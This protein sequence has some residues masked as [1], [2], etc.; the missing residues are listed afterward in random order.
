M[1][2]KSENRSSHVRLVACVLLCC[3]AAAGHGA[4]Q[5][6]VNRIQSVEKLVEKS[7]AANRILS[8]GNQSAIG[9]RSDA[10]NHLAGA[11]RAMDAGSQDEAD[12]LLNLATSTMFEAVRVLEQ[13]QDL[14]D[15]QQR[16]F[17]ERL[18]SVTALCEAYDRISQEKGLGPAS[19][20]ELHQIVHSKLGSARALRS[21]GRID[22]GRTLLDEAYVAAK[23][24]IEHLRGGDTLIRSLDFKSSEEE[25]H[26]EIDRNDTHRMLVQVLLKE[27]M[28]A[29]SGLESRVGKFMDD[30]DKLRSRA[31]T[32]ADSGDYEQ[33]VRTLEDSTREIVKAIR[34]AGIYIPG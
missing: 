12:R 2:L 5:A 22:E 1:I 33:A 34:S 26:Y 4:E 18:D 15:K 16:D 13:D 29:D 32:E 28:G 6:S 21:E 31:E 24:G 7:S 3:V 17:D 19:K 11:R 27:K 25:Y 30:A 20:S 9:L 10:Q 23:V 14:V 8:S